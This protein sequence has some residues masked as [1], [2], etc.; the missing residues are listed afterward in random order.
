MS[1]LKPLGPQAMLARMQELQAAFAPPQQ[2]GP[3]FQIPT[4]PSPAPL[5]GAITP[6]GSYEPLD[7]FGGGSGLRTTMSRD[8]IKPMIDKAAG[9]YGLDAD[10]LDALVQ[11]ESNYDPGAVSSKRAIG[12]TQLMPDTAKSLGVSD[13]FNPEANLRGGAKYLSQMLKQFNG[14]V[15]KA[16]AAYNAGPGTVT[17]YGGIPPYKETQ[18]Y[19]NKIMSLYEAKRAK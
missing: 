3:A 13:P 2:T 12:L 15:S 9:E 6:G 11:T 16:L 10:L 8:Q 7:P 19:V 4:Q 14:D 18:N 17:R 5:S 1:T